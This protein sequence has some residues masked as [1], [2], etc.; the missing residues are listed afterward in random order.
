[1]QG[2]RRRL[3]HGRALG[4][5]ALDPGPPDQGAE[6]DAPGC[7]A[8]PGVRRKEEGCSEAGCPAPARTAALWAFYSGAQGVRALPSRQVLEVSK[9]TEPGAGLGRGAPGKARPFAKVLILT[10]LGGSNGDPC[11]PLQPGKRGRVILH[12]EGAAKFRTVSPFSLSLSSHTPT[13]SPAYQ[14][15]LLWG[16]LGL[17]LGA[18]VDEGLWGVIQCPSNVWEEMPRAALWGACSGMVGRGRRGF[19]NGAFC[20]LQYPHTAHSLRDVEVHF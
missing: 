18:Q 9:S 1:M 11:N 2:R 6:E 14:A 15:E 13:S 4:R 12:L 19:L 10:P 7:W 17:L 8:R 3:G 20:S 16:E 5:M